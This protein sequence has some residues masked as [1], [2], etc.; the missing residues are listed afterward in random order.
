[1]GRSLIGLTAILSAASALQPVAAQTALPAGSAPWKADIVTSAPD[2]PVGYV[3]A[4]GVTFVPWAFSEAGYDSNP[5]QT[6]IDQK[7][8]AFIRSGGGFNVSAASPT[9]VATLSASGSMLDYFNDTV[10]DEPLR[11]AGT[12]KANVTYLVEPGFTVSSGAFINYDGQSVNENQ[13]AG[14]NLDLGYRD[15]LFASNLRGRFTN[16]QYLDNIG[17]P[18]PVALNSTFNYNRS[19]ATW[20]GLLGTH[21]FL[22]PYAEVSAARVDYTDQPDTAVLDRSADDYHAKSGVRLTLSPTLSTDI[23]WRFNW[24]D[25]DDHRITN[26][27]SNFFDGSLAWKPSP[28]FLFTASAERYIGEPSTNPAVLA[29]VRSYTVKGTYLP[30]P[31]VTVSAAGGWQVVSDIGSGVNYHAPYANAQVA[32]EYNNH[33]TFYT[34]LQY[35]GYDLDWQYQGYED[36]RVMAGVRIIPDGQDLLHGE[37]LESL[38][39]RLADAHRPLGSE[40]TVSGGYSWFGLPDMK[41]VNVVGG[42]F[43]NEALGQETNG[44]GSLNGW[45]TDA[46]LSNFAE[47]ATP[48]GNLLSFGVSGFFANYQGTTNSNCMYSLT[49]DCAI[50]NIADVSSTLPN[51][52]GPFGNLNVTARRDVNYYGTAVDARLGDWEGGGLKDGTAVQELSPFKVGVAMRGIDETANLNAA[53]QG[54]SYSIK[55][56]ETLDAHYYG[57]YV[58]YERKEPLGDGWMFGVDATAGI[59]YTDTEYQGRYNGYAFVFPIGYFPDSGNVNDSLDKGSFIGTV[60]LDLKRQ[61][62]W[63][64][65][66]VFGQ[67]EYLSYVPRIAYNNND[68]ANG[69]LWGGLAGN[70]AGTRIASSD[71][72]NFTTGLSVSVPVN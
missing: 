58:G 48:F 34:A 47:T 63:G 49:T 65:V 56:K 21:W 41:M 36:V 38:M 55:Y 25:T 42:P 14:A 35:Q 39:A 7:G 22:A 6:L 29:D 57:G 67:G 8:S 13:T 5:S 53:G 24:R 37:S 43:F 71:A 45:R 3:L 9:T 61:L 66:G 69:V 52:T 70:Q 40:L 32:W 59:Y 44:D 23:G 60:R 68:Q 50:V 2:A 10:F 51:N 64:M 30:V 19:E 62:E 27:E 4:S 11:F 28:F 72:F 12:A 18:S 1:M 33:V 16:V 20:I 54:V 15:D 46:R 17:M 31:G 26:Y